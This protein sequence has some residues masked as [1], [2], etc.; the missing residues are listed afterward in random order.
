MMGATT[1]VWVR[2]VVLVVLA[3]LATPSWTSPRTAVTVF[4]LPRGIL[5]VVGATA[6]VWVRV[7]F[8]VVLASLVVQRWRSRVHGHCVQA[9]TWHPASDFHCFCRDGL[10]ENIC[11]SVS[12]CYEAHYS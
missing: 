12:G 5:L 3:S 11:H 7:I 6:L 9:V 10:L 8:L 1:K 2:I 4:R